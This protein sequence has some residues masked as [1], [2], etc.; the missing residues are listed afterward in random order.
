MTNANY[1]M[2]ICI[3]WKT[4]NLRKVTTTITTITINNNNRNNNTVIDAKTIITNYQ[5]QSME[6][7]YECL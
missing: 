4:T 7:M 5:D 1:H 2:N 3:V 6:K